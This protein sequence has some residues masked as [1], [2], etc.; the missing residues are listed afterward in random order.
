MGDPKKHR[1]K[2]SKPAHPWNKDRILAEKDVAKEYGLRRKKEIWKMNS[3]LRNLASQAKTI[4]SS[5]TKQSEIEGELLMARVKRLGLLDEKGTVGD[6]LNLDIKNIMDRRLQTLLVRN[7]LAHSMLQ[8]RQMITHQHIMVN[9][10]KIT[11]PS[12]LVTVEEESTIAY[13]PHSPMNLVMAPET[14][15]AKPAAAKK[16]AEPKTEEKKEE[17]VQEEE[18]AG[19]EDVKKDED[20]ASDVKDEQVEKAEEK[21]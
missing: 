17:Q 6:I 20:V 12:Y 5:R 15:S 4:I 1:K 13:A 9:G 7:K 16:E 14:P 19:K 3:V 8:A 11:S 10:K 18:E 2:F 21:A